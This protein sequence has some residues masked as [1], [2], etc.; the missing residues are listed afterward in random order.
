MLQVRRLLRLL[1]ALQL[2]ASVRLLHE[3][4]ASARKLGGQLSL[5]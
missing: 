1:K 2:S 3:R 4:L 5:T